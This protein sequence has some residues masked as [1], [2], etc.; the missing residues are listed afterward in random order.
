MGHRYN[1]YSVGP[2]I[3]IS[4]LPRVTS[5]K[6]KFQTWLFQLQGRSYFAD[7]RMTFRQNFF[8]QDWFRNKLGVGLD[9]R[10]R[11]RVGVW[12]RVSVSKTVALLRFVTLR[13][14][15]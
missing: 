5:L 12:N 2:S 4:A 9:N 1:K 14:A 8:L 15:K 7:L 13:P 10:V 6:S 11:I 3:H